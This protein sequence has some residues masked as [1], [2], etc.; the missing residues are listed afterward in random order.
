MTKDYLN[1][2]KER[3]NKESFD[4]LTALE[5]SKVVDFVGEYVEFCNPESVFVRTDAI[6]DSNY[7]R[8]KAK[9]LGEEKSLNIKGHTI[10]FDSPFDQARDK[11]NTKYLVSKNLKSQD[12]LN[13]L[14]RDQGT[15]EVRDILKDIM[16]GKEMFVCFFCLGPIDSDFSIL[17]V[18]ITDSSYVAHSE[19]ILYRQVMNS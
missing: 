7:I 13:S 4:K 9:T 11:N 2:L 6:G 19:D 18:Q 8:E 17:A 16:K 15:N 5:N 12:Y 14:D 1:F 10:H 3:L